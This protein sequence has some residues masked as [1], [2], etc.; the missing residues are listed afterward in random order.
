VFETVSVTYIPLAYRIVAEDIATPDTV[1]F[2]T[3][4][5]RISRRPEDIYNLRDITS[6]PVY[7]LVGLGRS[8]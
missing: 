5:D 1:V 4:A 2:V 8:L 7:A 6:G 3:D